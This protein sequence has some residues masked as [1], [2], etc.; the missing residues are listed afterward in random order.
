MWSQYEPNVAFIFYF[1]QFVVA[2]SVSVVF[3][4]DMFCHVAVAYYSVTH[5]SNVLPCILLATLNC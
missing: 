2:S 3:V 1:F 5:N 4:I